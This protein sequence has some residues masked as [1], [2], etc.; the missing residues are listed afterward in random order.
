MRISKHIGIWR[1]PHRL[2]LFFF[3]LRQ[4]RIHWQMS[5]RYCQMKKKKIRLLYMCMISKAQE[6]KLLSS[7][8]P[9]WK[10][11]GK[12]SGLYLLEL[13][14]FSALLLPFLSY[15]QYLSQIPFSLNVKCIVVFL[16]WTE[17]KNHLHWFI[18]HLLNSHLL[19]GLSQFSMSKSPEWFLRAVFFFNVIFFFWFLFIFWDHVAGSGVL[20]FVREENSPQRSEVEGLWMFSQRSQEVECWLLLF[21]CYSRPREWCSLDS[22]CAC[23]EN[24][25][26]VRCFF[27]CFYNFCC[28]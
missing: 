6:L 28:T 18:D 13:S 1:E 4:V 21:S 25:L 9:F 10:S 20:Q 12:N 23:V 2:S 8:S 22:A 15:S 14:P 27:V 11:F 19:P 17:N 3:F 26:C 5:D 7:H 24:I 16:Q